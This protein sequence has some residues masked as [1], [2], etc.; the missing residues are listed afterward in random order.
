MTVWPIFRLPDQPPVGDLLEP[1]QSY[2]AVLKPPPISLPLAWPE[3][4]YVCWLY[5]VNTLRRRQ[6]R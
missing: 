3:E 2:P 5:R 6:V 4:P 1:Q